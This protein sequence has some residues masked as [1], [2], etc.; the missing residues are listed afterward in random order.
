MKTIWDE[1][2]E[3]ST[4][5]NLLL[6]RAPLSAVIS[7]AHRPLTDGSRVDTLHRDPIRIRV[8]IVDDNDLFRVGLAAL[9]AAQ[10]EVEVVGQASRGQN[11]VR[12]AGELR[13]DVVLM[14]LGMP[15]LS[16]S[17]ATRAILDR[18]PGARVAPGARAGCLWLAASAFGSANHVIV[19]T[20]ARPCGENVVL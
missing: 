6:R 11:G 19:K 2:W 18:D 1:T 10:P 16:G 15:D 7:G 14:D 8:L 3:A 5:S 17:D 12:L 9:L 4:C 13:P 20:P